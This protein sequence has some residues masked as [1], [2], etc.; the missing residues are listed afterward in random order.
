[1]P[2]PNKE[3]IK[4]I[5]TLAESTRI[6]ASSHIHGDKNRAAYIKAMKRCLNVCLDKQYKRNLDKVLNELE[7]LNLDTP[8]TLRERLEL[9]SNTKQYYMMG[10]THTI[11]IVNSINVRFV[12]GYSHAPEF[13]ARSVFKSVYENKI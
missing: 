12:R 5:E 6:H 7:K 2:N 1:M 9:F 3:L 10:I 8:K 4:L 13:F 11:D